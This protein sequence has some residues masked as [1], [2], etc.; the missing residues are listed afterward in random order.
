MESSAQVTASGS[1]SSISYNV[2]N[3]TS[4]AHLLVTSLA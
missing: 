1:A 3:N 2:Q 4:T